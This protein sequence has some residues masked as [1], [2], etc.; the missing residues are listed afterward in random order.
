MADIKRDIIVKNLLKKGF[1]ERD[2]SPGE[3]HVFH[4]SHPVCLNK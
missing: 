3:S 2:G 4:L 1:I